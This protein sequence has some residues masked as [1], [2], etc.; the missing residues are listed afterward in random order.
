MAAL[1]KIDQQADTSCAGHA[2]AEKQTVIQSTLDAEKS[3][4][5]ALQLEPATKPW[6][7][8]DAALRVNADLIRC[9][10]PILGTLPSSVCEYCIKESLQ[11]WWTQW[12]RFQITLAKSDGPGIYYARQAFRYMTLAAALNRFK[13]QWRELE[14]NMDVA[15][16]SEPASPFSETDSADVQ[17]ALKAM[18]PELRD[19]LIRHFIDNK[20]YLQLASESNVSQATAWRR[21]HHA[22]QVLRQLLEAMNTPE[23]QREA[24]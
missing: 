18:P 13:G 9:A 6:D 8:G 14:L 12:R 23:R 21:V 17:A 20:T 19:L 15:D 7:R 5:V 22:L 2:M 1:P 11:N 10:H 16:E 3:L 24:S 4:R